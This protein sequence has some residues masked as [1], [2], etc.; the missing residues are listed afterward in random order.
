[1]IK[2]TLFSRSA[3]LVIKSNPLDVAPLISFVDA[4]EKPLSDLAK[5]S[6]KNL[7]ALNCEELAFFT[8]CETLASHLGDSK[9]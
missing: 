2:L 6:K 7:V 3:L 5:R 4:F 1:M 9:S 8:L